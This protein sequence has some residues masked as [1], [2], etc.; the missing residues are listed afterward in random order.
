[1]SEFSRSS[2]EA[3]DTSDDNVVSMREYLLRQDDEPLDP[4]ELADE[5]VVEQ[6]LSQLSH[7]SALR[8]S[9]ELGEYI[10]RIIK[11]R[12]K[13]SLSGQDQAWRDRML[14]LMIEVDL[15]SDDELQLLLVSDP[16]LQ[17]IF[18]RLSATRVR[19]KELAEER[20]ALVLL[21]EVRAG[22]FLRN[23]TTPAG[24]NRWSALINRLI[25]IEN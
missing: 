24:D 4:T 21:R 8:P 10:Q 20:A 15:L 13:D 5:E 6:F 25:S 1:M 18:T 16:I 12:S 11:P 9:S 3:V 7:P 23:E 19:A 2:R 22:S 17:E 14:E